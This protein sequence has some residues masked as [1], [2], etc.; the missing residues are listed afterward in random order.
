MSL[1]EW[2]VVFEAADP[3]AADRAFRLLAEEGLTART[4][5]VE[6]VGVMTGLVQDHQVLT[7]T[8][9]ADRALEILELYDFTLHRGRPALPSS[10]DD[11]ASGD[12]RSGALTVA[13]L[14]GAMIALGILLVLMS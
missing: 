7:V 9:D 3:G 4:R 6:S 14:F 8:A 2:D 1:R 11:S 10:I 13:F 5:Q 12:T